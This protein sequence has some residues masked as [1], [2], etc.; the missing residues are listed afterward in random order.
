MIF[1]CSEHHLQHLNLCLQQVSLAPQRFHLL[2][3][4]TV[5]RALR[6]T[7]A[8]EVDTRESTSASSSLLSLVEEGASPRFFTS[9]SLC[10]M[11]LTIFCSSRQRWHSISVFSSAEMRNWDPVCMPPNQNVARAL[12]HSMHAY[13]APTA[14]YAAVRHALS[15]RGPCGIACR[16]RTRSIRRRLCQDSTQDVLV[17]GC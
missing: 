12:P 16:G 13:C 7:H 5:T 14:R 10:F 9:S 3:R 4:R 2:A 11:F 8:Q 17:G 1:T 6:R 15:A